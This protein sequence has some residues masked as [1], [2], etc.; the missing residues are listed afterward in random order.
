MVILH[1]HS[2]ESHMVYRVW[3]TPRYHAR[4][5]ISQK[6]TNLFSDNGYFAKAAMVAVSQAKALL[7]R[8]RWQS[9]RL[10]RFCAVAQCALLSLGNAFEIGRL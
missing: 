7:I 8:L 2:V 4:V 6:I 1:V 3:W 9:S 5:E 10:M